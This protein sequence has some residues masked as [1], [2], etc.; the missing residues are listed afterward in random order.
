[1][2]WKRVR[3][4]PGEEW[5]DVFLINRLVEGDKAAFLEFYHR[6]DRL[7]M[8]CIRSMVRDKPRL[9]PDDLLQDF[10]L[11]LQ[12]TAYRDLN[13]WT[14]QTPLPLFLRHIVHNFV[15]DRWRAD[16]TSPGRAD[17]PWSGRRHARSQ[18]RRELPTRAGKRCGAREHRGKPDWPAP[19]VWRAKRR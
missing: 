12:A 16:P 17:R 5:P 9:E 13:Q 10:F 18:P 11:K 7:I 14:R 4:G 15:I 19:P 6:F 8:H 2:I 1:M 3:P